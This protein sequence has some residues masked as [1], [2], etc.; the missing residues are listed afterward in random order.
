[1]DLSE[2]LDEAEQ[3]KKALGLLFDFTWDHC[4]L[5]IRPQVE[6][7][8]ELY[9]KVLAQI[10]EIDPSLILDLYQRLRDEISRLE[11]KGENCSRDELRR[12]GKLLLQLEQVEAVLSQGVRSNGEVKLVLMHYMGEPVF[13][14]EDEDWAKEAPEG[15][16]VYTLK[17]LSLLKSA[18]PE[19]RKLVHQLK[20]EGARIVDQ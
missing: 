15:F 16:V 13:F 20:K 19:Q 10:G 11:E 5:G 6:L 8:V 4:D 18:S 7:A 14:A 9:G 1:V 2:L 3:K 12:L 17:E